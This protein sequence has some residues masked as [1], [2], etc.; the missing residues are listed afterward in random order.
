MKKNIIII[1]IVISFLIL[2][3]L[4]FKDIQNIY[5]NIWNKETIKYDTKN[6]N[7]LKVGLITG[8]GGLGDKAFNDMQYN[9]LILAKNIFNIETQYFT[10]KTFDDIETYTQVLIDNGFNLII[11]GEGYIGQKIL[12]KFAPKYPDVKFVIL[13]SLIEKLYNNCASIL[14]K[15]N[16]ASFLAGVLAASITRRKRLG[17]IGGIEVE[18]IKDFY[19][20][21]EQ[22]IKYIKPD[23]K[24]ESD[25]ISNYIKDFEKV[26]NSPFE[27]YKIAKRM[28]IE[29]DVDIIFTVAAGSNIGIFNACR[30][31]SIF[32]IGVDIDQDH[33]IPG[34]IL[35][36]VLK[37]LDQAIV[38]I[39]GKVM[40][41]NFESK[42]YHIG[43]K[44]NGVGLSPMLYTK[45]IIGEKIIE[46]LAKLQQDIIEGKII[47]KSIFDK[48]Y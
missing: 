2:F 29:K 37:N 15:Q 14:F 4:F 34:V 44:E 46:H 33:I 39:I 18:V 26:W 35:T 31:Y 24:I 5:K 1:I 23:C 28:I 8:F 40:K 13:D 3:S 42:V 19:I 41:N 30:D 12:D 43:L 7:R 38:Y 16:E 32:S 45:N 6:E 17:F 36:S 22:G 25:Y 9:G 21:F 10:P 47:V 11:V 48:T 27:S 20:G